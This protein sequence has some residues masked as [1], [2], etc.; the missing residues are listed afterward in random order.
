MI[1]IS[2]SSKAF[3]LIEVNCVTVNVKTLCP[4][5]AKFLGRYTQ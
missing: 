2:A 4:V 5:A 1:E 3:F